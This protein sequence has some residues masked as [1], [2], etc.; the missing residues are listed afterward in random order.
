MR[1][2]GVPVGSRRRSGYQPG[3]GASDGAVPEVT[4][5]GGLRPERFRAAPTGT[6]RG[7]VR[8]VRRARCGDDVLGREAS[9]N[10]PG[11]SGPAPA[12]HGSLRLRRSGG[13]AWTM[14][15]PIGPRRRR[16]T[17]APSCRARHRRPL[18]GASV[19]R[20]GTRPID[21]SLTVESRARLRCHAAHHRF[22]GSLVDRRGSIG[23]AIHRPTGR[24]ARG[25]RPRRVRTSRVRS[26][27]AMA[28]PADLSRERRGGVSGCGRVG[29]AWW[30]LAYRA[31]SR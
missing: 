1:L 13:T 12:Y 14:G 28:E 24:K 25:Y 18:V 26:T 27:R 6:G 16:G 7:M 23:R 3:V 20:P 2:P 29:P 21:G 8:D 10:R 15:A 4:S 17:Q 9:S 22:V 19:C 11:R 31:P 5:T 30:A